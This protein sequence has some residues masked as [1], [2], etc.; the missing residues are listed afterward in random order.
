VREGEYGEYGVSRGVSGDL[1]GLRGEL[2]LEGEG[3]GRAQ[4]GRGTAGHGGT[5]ET[6]I[7]AGSPPGWM[8]CRPRS[9]H[10]SSS[11]IHFRHERTGV[12]AGGVRAA[13]WRAAACA[14]V[15]GSHGGG[16][17]AKSAEM[18]VRAG[19]VGG[20][21]STPATARGGL[22]FTAPTHEAPLQR[23]AGRGGTALP[24]AATWQAGLPPLA[25]TARGAVLLHNGVDGSV[26]T[27]TL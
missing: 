7:G 1:S 26:W 15:N 8:N 2:M 21:Q 12:A 20:S 16:G 11:R 19:G 22:R 17:R 4:G 13:A 24:S 25:L 5:V 3:G 9:L 27:G 18:A 14:P 23:C 10:V 6:V